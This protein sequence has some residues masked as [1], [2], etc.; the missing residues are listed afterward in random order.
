MLFSRLNRTDPEKVFISVKA[1][2]ALLIGRPVC[3]HF[4]GTDDGKVGYLADA[5]TDGTLVVGLADKAIASG[6]YGLVQCYGYRSDAQIINASDAAA[7]CGAVMAVGS[8]S[9][10]HLYMSVSVGAASG[11]QPNFVLALSASKTTSTTLYT[12]GVFIRCM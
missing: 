3:L 9:S 2:E 11:I 6:S 5:A 1:G 10:G 4:N 8:A 7:D 12:G